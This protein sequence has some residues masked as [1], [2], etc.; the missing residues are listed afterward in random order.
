MKIYK[1]IKEFPGSKFAVVTVGTFDGLHIGHQRIIS[2]MK[3][4]ASE[5]NGDTVLVTFDPHPRLVLNSSPTELRFI[6]SQ[7]R[8]MQLLENFGIDHM[9]AIPFTKEF[10]KTPSEVFIKDYLVDR[11]HV[12]KLIVGYDHHFGRNREGDY[13]QLIE[14]GEKFGFEVAEIAAQYIND[15]AVSSTKIRNALIE[16]DVKLANKMLGYNYSIAGTVIEGNKI[17]RKIGFPTA[18]IDVDDKYKL[19]AAGGVYACKVG[20]DGEI[21]NGMGNIGTRPTVG[22]NGLVTEVHIFDFDEDIYGQEI[23]IYF[24]DRIR[25]EKKFKDLETLQTQ[26]KKDEVE[27]RKLLHE[28]S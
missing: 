3:E 2:R 10:S 23:I 25:D 6:S 15:T 9:I 4:I 20:I 8:K 18:N 16:G 5:K 13:Q 24:I 14:T 21:Y 12:K 17:G 27:T 1:D 7:K 22:I 19:I 28:S 11:V 26:L